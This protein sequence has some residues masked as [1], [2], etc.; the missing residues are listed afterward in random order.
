MAGDKIALKKQWFITSNQA[1]ITTLYNFDKELGQGAYG[2]VMLATHIASN[3]RR[4]IKAIPKYR[5]KD[6]ATFKTEID[7]LR[8]LDHPNI[9][10]M[11]E[12]FETDRMCYVVLEYCEG[13][14]LFKRIVE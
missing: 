6:Y 5:V 14:E 11:I 13:G 1:D 9:V 4:A 2:K 12:T 8:D 3:Q 10:K 7:V